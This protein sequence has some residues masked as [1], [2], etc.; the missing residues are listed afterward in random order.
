ARDRAE[1]ADPPGKEDSFGDRLNWELLLRHV[2][3]F[4][5]IH[6]VS[7]DSDYASLIDTTKPHPVLTKEWEGQKGAHLILHTEL[8]TFL[9]THFPDIKVV[10][11]I[12]R[13]AAI[14][15]LKSSGAFWVT[16]SA[17]AKLKEFE[18]LLAAAE[19]DEL[20]AA[21]LKNSQIRMIGHDSDVS[22]FYKR[23]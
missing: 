5:D 4:S 8:R 13:R 23:I 2:D 18:A 12:E 6:V 21:G 15:A 10:T 3:F 22:A 11:D 20:V 14:E 7:K 19:I 9:A 1:R 16:H 17:I